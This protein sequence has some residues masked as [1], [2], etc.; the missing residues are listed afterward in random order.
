ML[1]VGDGEIVVVVGM[2]FDCL[3][4]L[5]GCKGCYVVE[6]VYLCFFVVEVVVYV[7][8]IDYYGIGWDMQYMC[9]YMLYF[10]WVLG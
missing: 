10:G 8:Y 9:Y 2:Q 4:Q 3:F 7:L 1:F 5:F 6:E